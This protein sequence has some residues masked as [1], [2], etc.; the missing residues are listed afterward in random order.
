MAV[1][2][3]KFAQ[4]DSVGTQN[5]GVKQKTLRKAEEKSGGPNQEG[6]GC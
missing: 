3:V 5:N 6:G 4:Y 2:V 1:V